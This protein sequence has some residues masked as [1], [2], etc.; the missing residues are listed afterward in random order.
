V[1][2]L[3]HINIAME[4]SMLVSHSACPRVG[5]LDV[6]FHAFSYINQYNKVVWSEADQLDYNWTDFY[7]DDWEAIPVNAPKPLGAT[8]QMTAFVDVD[9]AGN[10]LTR[11]SHTGVLRSLTYLMVHKTAEHC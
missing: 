1:V 7:G 3:G 10:M 2:E 5:H 11:R 8:V 6:V 4:V 9:N